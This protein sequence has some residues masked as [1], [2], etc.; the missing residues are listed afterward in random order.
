MSKYCPWTS[1]KQIV[2]TCFRTSRM[3]CPIEILKILKTGNR[4]IRMRSLAVC[5]VHSLEN[6][7][8]RTLTSDRTMVLCPLR[9]HKWGRSSEVGA[10]ER[11]KLSRDPTTELAEA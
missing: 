4:P 9:P 6:C 11:D 1:D 7:G 10:I 3:L 8:L 5:E 2:P